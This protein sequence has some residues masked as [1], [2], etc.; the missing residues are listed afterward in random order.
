MKISDG[1][2]DFMSYKTYYIVYGDLSSEQTPLVVLHGGPGYP[3]YYLENI[4]VLAEHERPVVFYDQ[5]GCG[6]SDRPD[7]PELWTIELYTEELNVIRKALNLNTINLLGQS[8]GGTLALEYMFT[9]PKGVEKLILADP[10]VDTKLWVNEA[11]RLI[12]E[13]PRWAAD[14]M[15]EHEAKGTTDSFEYRE[16]YAVFKKKHICQLEPYPKAMAKSDNEAGQPYT[17]M[18]GPNE[19]TVTGV[20]KDWTS[21]DR[22]HEI[23]IPTLFISGEY[24]EATPK[25]IEIAKNL[26]PGSEWVLMEGCSHTPNLEQP[27]KFMKNVSDFLK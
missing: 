20:L 14:I 9:K 25:Q 7:N 10:L 23:K 6:K 22:I 15:I 2:V 17:V 3:H 18:W 16:A 11:K 21:L 27:E 26:L 19:T 13:L 12:K 24:D 5:L 4:S 1:Y 8:W